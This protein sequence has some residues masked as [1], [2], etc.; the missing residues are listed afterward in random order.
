MSTRAEFSNEQIASLDWG[1]GDGLLPA[2]VQHAVTGE[3]L[4]LGFMNAQSLRVTLESKRVTFFSRSKQRLWTKGETS[5]NFLHLVDVADDCDRDS[6]LITAHPDGPTCHNGTISCFGTAPRTQASSFAF[7]AQL[8]TVI[9]QRVTER[10][11][12]SYTARLW[13]EGKGRLAQKVGEEGVEVALAAVTQSP[14]ALLGEA[15]DLVFHLALLL[16]S[17]DLSL[18]DVVVELE[19]RHRK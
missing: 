5:G 7:L 3:V 14:A 2:I 1:K 8:E 9:A 15:A 10:P 17:R 6:L 16:K 11:E 12:G 13:A 4:M 18:A 19:R